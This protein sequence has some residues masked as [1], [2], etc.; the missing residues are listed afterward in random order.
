MFARLPR[1][2]LASVA[3]DLNVSVGTNVIIEALDY[4]SV[5]LAGYYSWP[6]LLSEA[7]YTFRAPLTGTG[8]L[9]LDNVF[10]ISDISTVDDY[11]YVNENWRLVIGLHDYP[12]KTCLPGVITLDTSKVSVVPVTDASFRLF[13][14]ALTMP[15]DFRPGSDFTAYNTTLRYRVKH[16]N[17]IAFEKHWQAYKMMSSNVSLAYTDIEPFYDNGLVPAWRYRIQFCPPPVGDTQIRISYQR[18]PN[19]IDVVTNAPTEWPTGY[20]EIIELLALGRIGEKNGDAGAVVAARRAQGLIR[21]L[22]GAVATAVID[23]TPVQNSG[24]GQASFEEG[25]LSVLPRETF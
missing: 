23:E 3:R 10:T 11:G 20:D 7:T 18:M 22:R 6:W 25:G 21:Q 1:E 17:R 15:A 2:M 14:A 19:R 24:Y 5:Q 8:T 13:Q 12:V 4:A 16:L 9:G